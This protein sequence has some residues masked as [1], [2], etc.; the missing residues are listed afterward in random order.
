[1]FKVH[2]ILEFVY[3]NLLKWCLFAR[4]PLTTYNGKKDEPTADH[5]L[6]GSE[7]VLSITTLTRTCNSGDSALYTAFETNK[8]QLDIEYFAIV[9]KAHAQ[10]Y[11]GKHVLT[12]TH[13]HTNAYMYC[14]QIH[15]S[16]GVHTH[17]HRHTDT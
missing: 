9:S 1:M 10:R 3:T 12:Y 7:A 4:K 5:N 14:M 17:L 6:S 15:T 13:T 8:R 11:M 16:V 2:S